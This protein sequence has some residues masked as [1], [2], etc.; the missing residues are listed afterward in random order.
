MREFDENINNLTSLW[1]SVGQV[2]GK[3]IQCRG[4]SY[5]LIPGSDWPN[6]IWFTEK[7]NELSL[8]AISEIM[9]HSS[10]PL[11]LSDWTYPDGSLSGLDQ[12]TFI[13]KS[14]QIGMS[15]FLEQ[16]FSHQDRIILER[17]I[18]RKQ[19]LIWE[20]LY[21]QS[22]GYGIS[23]DKPL[24]D[25]EQISFFIIYLDLQPVGT[26][27]T[28]ATDNNIGIHGLGIIP[29]F[30]KQG[31][32]EEVMARILNKA[33]R[34]GKRKALLQSSAMGKNI[35]LKLGFSEDFV[36]TNYAYSTYVS[37]SHG[38]HKPQYRV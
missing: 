1:K 34:D 25:Q 12:Y 18:D 30:R 24:M 33:L 26:V 20:T 5:S 14:E 16:E 11:I 19:A 35:Y 2:S 21:P 22:F 6:R 28:I 10:I 3:F 31:I 8:L 4:F 37:I 36:L 15:L 9:K 38:N 23:L 32:A 29:E 17:V 7:A 27:F 13:K